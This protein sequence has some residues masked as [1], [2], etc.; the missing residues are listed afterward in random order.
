MPNIEIA[1]LP[2]ETQSA[3]SPAPV[4]ATE[5]QLETQAQTETIVQE[6]IEYGGYSSSIFEK[7]LF[8]ALLRSAISDE[9]IAYYSI[10]DAGQGR[11]K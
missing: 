9:D 6:D 10:C 8:A 4:S 7:A 11:R 2:I 3:T 1:A 5:Q